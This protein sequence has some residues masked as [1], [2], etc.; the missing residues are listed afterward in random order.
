[1]VKIVYGNK[2]LSYVSDSDSDERVLKM[3]KGQSGMNC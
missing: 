3:I 2:T 1:M